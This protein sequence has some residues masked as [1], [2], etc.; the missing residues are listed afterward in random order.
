MGFFFYIVKGNGFGT[1]FVIEGNEHFII[2]QENCVDKRI[3]QH[4]P[5]FLFR[6]IQLTEPMQPEG[7]EL[8]TDFRFCQLLQGNLVFQLVTAVLQ[9][10]QPSLGRLGENALLNGVE[11]VVDAHIDLTELLLVQGQI[12][13]LPVL[14]VHKHGNNGFNGVVI[15]QHF[16]GGID[17]QI[18][19]PLLADSLFVA[20]PTLFLDGHALVIVVDST[21][22]TCAAFT[23]QIGSTVTAEQLGGQQITSSAL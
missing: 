8:G 22:S 2:V 4:L 13:V 12:D 15:V 21:A 20:V 16:H 17:H 23:A 7:H 18:L 19:D 5:V 6:H 3:N 10:L 9:F 1:L 14:Q 11:Q